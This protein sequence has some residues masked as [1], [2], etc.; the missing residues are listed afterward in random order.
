MKNDKNTFTTLHDWL[1]R[2]ESFHPKAIEMGLDRMNAVAQKF[3]RSSFDCPVVTIG[4]TNGKG[5][6][7]A[8][9][10]AI[11]TAAGY[12]VGAYT[13]PHLLRFNERIIIQNQMVSDSDLIK[14]FQ[15]VEQARGDIPLT[16]FEFTTLAALW[17]F[18]Q[19]EL[20][21]ILLEVG[22]GGR[23]DAVNWVDSDIA[24]V[25]TVA[26]D[27][28]DWLG[29]NTE[30]IGRE[31]A[32]IFRAGKPAI[33][34]DFSPPA[35][36][37]AVAKALNSDLYCIHHE[38]RE[39]Y[40]PNNNTF[41][42]SSATCALTDLP[43][44]RLPLQNASTALMAVECLQS[45]LPVTLTAIKKGLSH[46]FLPG[47]FQRLIHPAGVEII[48]D[49]AHNPAAARLL[50]R[51]IKEQ[52]INKGQTCA[53]VGML[54]D[55]DMLSTLQPLL[56]CVDKWFVAGLQ[57]ET[58][59]GADSMKLANILL[60]LGVRGIHQSES[61]EKAFQSALQTIKPKDRLLIF[62]SFY[63]IS[64]VLNTLQD[65]VSFLPH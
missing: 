15:K 13:S 58:P 45:R 37:M 49:V 59:R 60:G 56:P 47:R 64:S 55:K 7:V 48:L 62:G 65:T 54:S 31:K 20:D 33:C 10:N 44:P 27:H 17:L 2:I 29:D 36:L 41:S 26:L 43:L 24:I 4:G 34:G 5:S 8:F 42:W 63:M 18:Q 46:A 39:H 11:F 6:C 38:F 19:A 52:P 35:S 21:L 53:M 22:L 50:A 16:F 28:M 3:I 57:H 14:A 40:T 51:Q 61:P 1:N 9:L 25:T 30:A 23:L 12:R 32:G